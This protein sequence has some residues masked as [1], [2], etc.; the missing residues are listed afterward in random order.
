MS[1]FKIGKIGVKVFNDVDETAQAYYGMRVY[2]H[3]NKLIAEKVCEEDFDEDDGQANWEYQDIQ[4]G[5]ELLG[6]YGQVW[7][8]GFIRRL[9]F[10]VDSPE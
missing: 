10:V 8:D 5:Q 6:L 7:A 9:G 4:E 1:K 2:D 3:R